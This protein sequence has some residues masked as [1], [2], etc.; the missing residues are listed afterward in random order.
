MPPVAQTLQKDYPE[1]L[2]ATRLRSYGKQRILIGNQTYKQDELAYVD[3]NFFSIFTLPFVSGDANTALI[4]PNSIVISETV[5]GRYFKNENPLGKSIDFTGLHVTYTIRGI[6]KDIPE[7]SHFHF[8]MF[9]SMATLPEA[10]E[11]SWMTSNFY[12]YLLLQKNYDYK[13]LEAKLPAVVEKY[14]GPQLQQATGISFEAFRKAGNNLG[15][16]LEPLTDIH[17]KSDVLF[18][19]SE[20]G[21][22]RYVY[23][24][25]IIALFMLLIACINFMNL[26]TASAG[27]RSKEVGIRKVLGSRKHQLVGQFLAESIVCSFISLALA[28]LLVKLALPFFNTLS[29]K[30]LSFTLL[31]NPVNIVMLVAFGLLTG[32][33]AG[34][35][36]AFFLSS[37]NTISVLKSKFTS[38]K[39]SIGLRSGLVVFQFFISITLIV[40]TI[41]VYNQLHYINHKELG[42]NKEQVLLIEESYLLGKN[43]TL[44]HD[45]I[46]NDQR[47]TSVSTSSFLP[48]GP[49]GANNFM[50]YPDFNQTQLVKT[51]RYDVDAQYIPTLGMQMLAGRNFSENMASDSNAIILNETGVKALGWK[52]EAT[53]HTITYTSNNGQKQTYN[54]I[55]VVKDFHFKSL[56]Q[57]ISPLVMTLGH[58]SGTIIARIQ[59]KDVSGLLSTLK[60]QWNSFTKEEPFVYN[61]LDERFRQTYEKEQK[62]SLILTVFACLTILVG[63]LGLFGLA[64][65]TAEQRTKEIGIRKVLGASVSG[66]VAML[67]KDFLKLVGIA[68]VIACPLSWYIMNK[69]LQDFAYRINVEWWVFVVA[70]LVA[71]IIT[72]LSVSLKAIKAA[73]ANP[74]KS[75]RSE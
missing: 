45:L 16:F 38:G 48:A 10:S 57:P 31:N 1:V 28:L 43:E 36:P 29:A 42:Y 51:L 70:A 71:V 26:S 58:N 65:F 21:D 17:L 63:C 41:V 2:A 60:T 13:K 40:C 9:G 56:H 27:K 12:T 52:N 62:M 47:V 37:F 61:F 75:L 18:D 67:T 50:V 73:I 34:S 69:W 5:A 4:E 74:V 53:G 8:D 46:K 22:I 23:I 32:T 20:G 68:F 30:N 55:G 11:Q 72:L 19:L 59:A 24:F 15:L 14:M 39:Q 44:L 6:I 49:S 54:V 35:Y 33:L 25:G 64:A 3:S 7:N 66:V